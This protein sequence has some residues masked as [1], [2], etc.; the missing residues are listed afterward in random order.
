LFIHGGRNDESPSNC[1]FFLDTS[2][3]V[4]KKV[5][6]MD[7]PIARYYHACA[8][9]NNKEIFIFGGFN[10]KKNNNFGDLHKFDY[11]NLQFDSHD[12]DRVGGAYWNLIYDSV[13]NF[14]I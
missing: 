7:Q 8:K 14:L 6:T 2:Q 12:W 10:E 13:S 11:N 3:M 4:W 9:T 1:T 5:F